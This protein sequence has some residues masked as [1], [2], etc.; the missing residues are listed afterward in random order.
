M[1]LRKSKLLKTLTDNVKQG[2]TRAREMKALQ[3]SV[4]R[5][6]RDLGKKIRMARNV[7]THIRRQYRHNFQDV[8]RGNKLVADM[9]EL[10]TRIEKALK[11]RSKDD[12]RELE[13][14]LRRREVEAGLLMGDIERRLK[15][16]EMIQRMI[17]TL[18]R[19]VAKMGKGDTM[20]K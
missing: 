11:G 12:L 20:G 3:R 18:R 4:E 14:S 1:G 19:E 8:K 13:K 17:V 5:Y 9:N 7:L 10:E 16:L 2:Q 6:I 15:R